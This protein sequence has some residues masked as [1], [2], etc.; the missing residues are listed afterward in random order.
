[1]P[2]KYPKSTKRG[3]QYSP[4]KDKVHEA[5]SDLHGWEERALEEVAEEFNMAEPAF[6]GGPIKP[7]DLVMTYSWKCEKSPLRYCIFHPPT[8]PGDCDSC[9]F[10]GSPDERK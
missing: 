9:I 7:E 1:M 10:C 4:L 8:D 5:E 2:N 6:E 3:E